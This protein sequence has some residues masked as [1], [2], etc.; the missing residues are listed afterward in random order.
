MT[1]TVNYQGLQIS[2]SCK[3]LYIHSG[4]SNYCRNTDSVYEISYKEGSTNKEIGK[5]FGIKAVGREQKLRSMSRAEIFPNVTVTINGLKFIKTTY[6][7]HI[8]RIVLIGDGKSQVIQTY[9]YTTILISEKDRRDKSLMSA[10]L[11][12]I[13]GQSLLYLKP[14]A[15]KKCLETW[16]WRN[17]PR[18][19]ID[20]KSL[21]LTSDSEVIYYLRSKYDNYRIR[22]IDYQNQFIEEIRKRLDEYGVELVR[23]NREKTLTRTSY[24]SY[25]FSQTPSAYLH[26]MYRDESNQVT[27]KR[28]N[29]EFELRTNNTQLFFDFKNRYINVDLL[30][31]FCEMTTM[32]KY[33]DLWTSAIKWGRITE[34]FSQMYEQDNNQNFS[35]SCQFNAELFFYEAYDTNIGFIKE[36]LLEL[37]DFDDNDNVQTQKI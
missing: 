33:G 15:A 34:D 27:S 10:I 16:E 37:T 8:F 17:F 5:L 24:L 12:G 32:D 3:Y 36:I 2:S 22:N 7:P 29:I 35:L 18:L 25:R 9:D 19:I 13:N 30:T 4:D 14:V 31:N 21:D 1:N 28:L 26:P 23:Y 20:N 11:C 6:D